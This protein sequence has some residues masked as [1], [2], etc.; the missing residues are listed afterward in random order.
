[1]KTVKLFLVLVILRSF[2]KPILTTKETPKR[3][4]SKK[5]FILSKIYTIAFL[6]IMFTK[7]PI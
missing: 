2:G 6:S 5:K 1:M 4:K 3:G 7:K